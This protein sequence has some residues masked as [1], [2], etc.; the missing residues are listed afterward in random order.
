LLAL[1]TNPNGRYEITQLITG[2]ASLWQSGNRPRNS[3]RTNDETV[4][5]SGSA[6]HPAI[7]N[8]Q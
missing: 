4:V 2:T 6:Y 1:L 7:A 3:A 8:F 5:R